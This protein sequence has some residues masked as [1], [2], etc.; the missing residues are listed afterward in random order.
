MQWRTRFFQFLQ[1]ATE[2]QAVGAL[3][4]GT[5]Q[6]VRPV[7]EKLLSGIKRLGLL[8]REQYVFFELHCLVDDQ[9]QQDLLSIARDLAS[10]PEGMRDLRSGMRTALALR[11]EFW[12][13]MLE[14]SN[15]TREAH[16]A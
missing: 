5:E 6:I 7:Y 15:R 9:H 4:L 16:S 2:A 14:A 3:G 8:T 12:D 10:T 11:C 1:N 13:H